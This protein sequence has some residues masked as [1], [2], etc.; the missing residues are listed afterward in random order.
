[1][2]KPRTNT[3]EAL[4]ALI[5]ERQQYE[6][7][8]STLKAKRSGTSETVFNRVYADYR[9]RLE[10]VVEQVRSHADELQVSI[11]EVSN[12]LHEVARDEEAKRD[13][14]QEAELR[15]AVGEYD[16]T[17][18]ES[19]RTDASLELEKI[20]ASRSGL[21]AQLSELEGI[22]KLSEV[23]VPSDEAGEP[24]ATSPADTSSPPAAGPGDTFR[25]YFG[26]ESADAA[27]VAVPEKT[28][29]SA[30]P[31]TGG[32]IAPETAPGNKSDGRSTDGR[33]DQ[34][35][36]ERRPPVDAGWPQRE[37]AV[38]ASAPAAAA[39]GPTAAAAAAARFRNRSGAVGDQPAAPPAPAGSEMPGRAM[40][41]QQRTAENTAA[42]G[43]PS[44][45]AG[46][47]PA[48]RK[49]TPT[50]A[51]PLVSSTDPAVAAPRPSATPVAPPPAPAPPPRR[52]RDT[53]VGKD[54]Q[55]SSGF[56]RPVQTPADG[57]PEVNKTLKCPECGT[58]NY[59]TEWY[60]ERCGGE[61]ATM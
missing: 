26:N 41:H 33:E 29:L 36:P 17:Q 21:E 14:I 6:Q 46:S 51:Q 4:R 1:M 18:W 37:V 32:A 52:R 49:S 53:P 60:C 20:A 58:P 8:I 24:V 30:Q 45:Q 9:G 42:S 35:T 19:M 54:S 3:L 2:T 12:K 34:Q 43:G 16:A 31:A 61:L 55:F 22:R 44:S 7:W 28:P 11:K 59:P 40:D 10:R 50:V 27:G 56:S 5:S 15:A 48:P 25:L 38:D 13:S 47:S 57:R 23:T 39:T